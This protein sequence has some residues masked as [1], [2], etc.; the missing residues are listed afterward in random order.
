MVPINEE[1]IMIDIVKKL[2]LPVLVV[3]ENKL[4]AIN[5]TVL[6]VE[7]LR[8]RDMQIIGIIF[9]RCSKGQNEYI[10]ED[11]PKIIKKLTGVEIL[12]EVPFN[13]DIAELYETFRPVGQNIL[14]AL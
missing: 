11:N 6:T 10:L 14:Q 2:N 3:T 1:K 8:K 12:G 13:K 9:D 7:A 5:Q 4:G